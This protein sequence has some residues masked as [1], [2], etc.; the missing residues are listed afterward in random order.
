MSTETDLKP[1]LHQPVVLK[2]AEGKTVRRED[3]TKLPEKGDTVIY[4]PYWVR[5]K[6]DEDVVIVSIP[7]QEKKAK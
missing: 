4:T 6:E 1:V 3:G 5:R 7:G 2:P